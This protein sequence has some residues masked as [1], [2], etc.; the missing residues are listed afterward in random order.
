[1]TQWLAVRMTSSRM[2]VPVQAPPAVVD[3]REIP[4]TCEV[5]W[6]FGDMMMGFVQYNASGHVAATN[7]RLACDSPSCGS[8]RRPAVTGRTRGSS[9]PRA[10]KYK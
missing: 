4:D 9:P 3:N 1:M 5:H 8:T 2:R 6:D 10:A 7:A